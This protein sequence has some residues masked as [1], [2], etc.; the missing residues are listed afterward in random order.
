MVICY[1]TK[2]V[3]LAHLSEEN[4][5]PE[6]AYCTVV[7]YLQSVGIEANKDINICVAPPS[8]ISPL[9]YLK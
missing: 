5:T 1:G 7:D 2:Q 8:T 3:M 4:N 9:F 6:L